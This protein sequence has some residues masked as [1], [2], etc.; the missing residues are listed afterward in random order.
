MLKCVEAQN[1]CK[2][3]KDR[4][5]IQA[6]VLS[7]NFWHFLWNFQQLRLFCAWLKAK[8]INLNSS[9]MSEGKFIVVDSLCKNSV[10]PLWPNVVMYLCMNIRLE[11]T[12][13]HNLYNLRLTSEIRRNILNILIWFSSF[14]Q[15][16]ACQKGGRRHE[17]TR[18]ERQKRTEGWW[19]FHRVP[20]YILHPGFDLKAGLAF[21]SHLFFVF[22][23]KAE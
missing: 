21:E 2:T 7:L 13:T 23:Y 3:F 17:V 12:N 8:Y 6:N 4:S 5:Y 15:K 16:C 10:T 22:S 19:I 14:L 18:K 20:S 11:T 1:T 9:M